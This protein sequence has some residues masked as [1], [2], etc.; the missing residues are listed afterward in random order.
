MFFTKPIVFLLIYFFL[1]LMLIIFFISFPN[2]V[3]PNG[4]DFMR[5][6][7]PSN[8]PFVD[9]FY[10]TFENYHRLPSKE[11]SFSFLTDNL[12]LLSLFI[13]F[14]LI[15]F[16]I[17]Q[18]KNSYRELCFYGSSLCFL[19]ILFMFSMFSP[20]CLSFQFFNEYTF[21]D[22]SV[23]R[24]NFVL[25]IDGFSIYF[26]V[27]TGFIMPLSFFLEFRNKT[28]YFQ[29]SFLVSLLFIEFFLIIAF[30]SLDLLI[31]FLAFESIL[32][33]MFLMIGIF[34]TNKRRIKA[35]FFFLMYSF[36]FSLFS[37]FLIVYIYS[38]T[39]TTNFLILIDYCFNSNQQIFAWALLF[40]TFSAKIPMFPFH[41][42]LPEAHVEAPTV[43]SMILASLLLKLGGY[44]FLRFSLPL[45][46]EGTFFFLPLVKVLAILSIF[47]A[48]LAAIYQLDLKK[49]VAYSSIAHMN[50]GI[51]G[52]FSLHPAGIQGSIF[53]M[54]SHGIISAALFFIIGIIYDRFNTRS[55]MYLGGLCQITPLLSSFFFFFM[56]C[57]IAFPGTSAFV[58]EFLT[59]IGIFS[60]NIFV[61]FTTLIG[62]FLCV[63]YSIRT[64]SFI[65][66]GC[67]PSNNYLKF[68][69]PTDI[70]KEEL[71]ILVSLTIPAVFIGI[72]PN[73]FLDLS[74]GPTKF[75]LNSFY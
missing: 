50:L 11:D 75:L 13:L 51:L 19:F 74:Y 7:N 56:V 63:V 71:R 69:T 9:K 35:S 54:I 3:Y 57:N 23:L 48:S 18:K 32:I 8:Y 44:G 59:L 28:Y 62:S 73:V 43:G 16:S 53:T 65:N 70:T 31:F 4:V 55:V 20:Y 49:I 2:G 22:N 66:F 37:F 61:F 5:W 25:G 33:P 42:W 14:L 52:I 1:S 40:I 21:I 15:F 39:G 41:I 45:F 46:P 68:K 12:I 17:F 26:V 38:V 24:L 72:K 29:K 60:S 34:G 58:G 47:Y 6:R 36:I 64:F 67:I 10:A 30:T 27:L